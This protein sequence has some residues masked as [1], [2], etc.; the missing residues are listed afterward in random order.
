M[1][2]DNTNDV[3]RLDEA[4]SILCFAQMLS[5]EGHNFSVNL[6]RNTSKSEAKATL[7]QIWQSTELS[8]LDFANEVAAFFSLRRL[9]LPELTE[10][11]PLVD[12]FS[13]G[14]CVKRRY[15][16]LRQAAGKSRWPSAIPEIGKR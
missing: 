10:C 7:K 14:S 4:D 8:G 1:I 16:R 15:S 5:D 9:S 13:P 3:E 2:V 6:V 11:R 12:R